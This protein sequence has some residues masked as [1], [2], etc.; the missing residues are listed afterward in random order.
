MA[1]RQS[2]PRMRDDVEGEIPVAPGMSNLVRGRSPERNATKDERA[3]MVGEFLLAASAFVAHEA[4]G[5]KFLD[6]T[7]GETNRR[8]YGLKRVES[9]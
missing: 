5:I 3:R 9:R 6:G 8:K 7:I 1:K 4:D 2:V